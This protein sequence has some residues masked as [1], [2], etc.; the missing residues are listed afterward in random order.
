VTQL[1]LF[2]FFFPPFSHSLLSLSL[3]TLF[4]FFLLLQQLSW[5]AKVFVKKAI[6]SSLLSHVL[7]KLGS[8]F[9]SR[10]ESLSLEEL[11]S[12]YQ[13]VVTFSSD[14]TGLLSGAGYTQEQ[15][16]EAIVAFLTPFFS[17]Q[18][19]YPT[20]EKT[21]LTEALKPYMT[22]SILFLASSRSLCSFS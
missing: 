7:S 4:S 17:F 3:H 20:L 18:K 12:I 15:I 14:A 6:V 10:L 13:V 5:S 2:S 8:S 22:V 21:N 1:S 19:R 11:I 9:K 16:D